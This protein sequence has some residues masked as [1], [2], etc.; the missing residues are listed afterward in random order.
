MAQRV[1]PALEIRL[2]GPFRVVAGGR[3]VAES[4]W[5]RRKPAL[6]IKLLALEPHYQ[7]HREQ[8]MERLWPGLDPRAAGNNLHKAI[9]LARR[10]L[11]PGLQAGARSLFIL[12]RGQQVLL[13]APGGLR[14]DALEF[15]RA[16]AEALKSEV[17]NACEAALALYRGDLLI[18]DPYEDWAAARREALRG[19]RRELLLRLTGLHESHGRHRE[20]IAP[21]QALVALDPTDEEAHRRLMRLYALAGERGLALAQFDLCRE[22]LHRELE[23]EP[24]SST[25]QLHA[26]IA[27]GL[28]D[29]APAAPLTPPRATGVNTLA[30]LPFADMSGEPDAD[31]LSEG[32]TEAII[33]NLS[34]LPALR[35]MA[36]STV[37]RYQGRDGDP[38]DVGRELG[39]GALATGRILRVGDSLV[40]RAEL[41]ETTTGSQLWGEQYSRHLTDL[42]AIQ[43]EIAR[44]I[45]EALRL[46][47]TGEEQRRLALRQTA[48][49]EAF[50]EYLMGR[51]CWNK[52]T[53]EGLKK[54][55][56]HYRR[57]IEADPAYALAHAGLAESYV[58][59][60]SF[61]V[62]ALAPAEA[63]PRARQA[64]TDAL[65]IDDTLAEARAAL[66]FSLQSYY[67]D[68]E[69]AEREFA[70]AIELKPECTTAHH[71][72]GLEYLTARGRLEEALAEVRRAHEL[73]PLS[74]NINTDLG[75]LP[76]LMRDYDLAIREY[77]KALEQDGDFVYTRWKLG[78]AY[79]QKGMYDEAVAE[80]RRAVQLSG[81]T[82]QA[83]ALL[84]R[85]YA[86]GRMKAE[87]LRV[88]D[89]L[90]ELSKH[91]YVSSYRVALIHSALGD[92]DRAF[93]WLGHALRERDS[94][95]V[96]LNVDPSLD[97]LRP[98]PRFADLVRH[99]GLTL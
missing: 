52:R 71:W 48:S 54:G 43:G 13:R 16:A 62:G 23:A 3:E 44:R 68:W 63:F 70:R 34:Q 81:G 98:A 90:D 95:L 88:L 51:Y 26:R 80:F 85:A 75:F 14:V 46:K 58:V 22:A 53:A 47:L 4:L 65:R 56:E 72:Y 78:L 7:L 42:L 89:E 35:V 28:L 10:A 99:V 55:I 29:P 93:E 19:L 57:A 20:G 18:E 66:A 11:E 31:Y 96:W 73:E 84:G 6:L 64:A 49:T 38:R 69:A 60:G 83:L 21:L 15:E 91:R 32:I 74:P 61:G 86:A 79:E 92:R 2:L 1:P 24:E 33:N 50:H 30:V 97:D 45:S 9:Y 8:A 59:L 27:A 82:A 76:Y 5:S 37:F 87:A 40:V 25:A 36:R 39:V 41:V 12:T 17:A 67:W 94:W 77:R